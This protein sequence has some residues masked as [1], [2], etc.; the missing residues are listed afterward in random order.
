MSVHMTA[1]LVFADKA[2]QT[3]FV[4]IHTHTK[5]FVFQDHFFPLLHQYQ[6]LS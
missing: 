5:T 4:H 1:I 3:E 6:T 2:I